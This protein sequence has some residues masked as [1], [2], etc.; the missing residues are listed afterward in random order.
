[1]S[2]TLVRRAAAGLGLAL[3]A[4]ALSAAP[5]SAAY[6][7][8]CGSGYSEVNKTSVSGGTVFLTY[9]NSN[10]R[11]CVVVERSSPGAA[12][13]MDAALKRSDS[14]AWQTDPGN[15]TQYAG[16]V[17]LDAAGRCVDWGGVIGG[18]WVVRTGTNCG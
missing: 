17:Y 7:G 4:T 9:N 6:G 3:A 5:A 15:F 12:M 13:N 1:M 16:P 11:N 8:Q 18:E 2:R 10:G 14:E